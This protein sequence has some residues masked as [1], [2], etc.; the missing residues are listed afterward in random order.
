[1][2]IRIG[3]RGK[4]Q[5]AQITGVQTLKGY[6]LSVGVNATVPSGALPDV[7]MGFAS[8]D[9]NTAILARKLVEALESAGIDWRDD[10]THRCACGASLENEQVLDECDACFAKRCIPCDRC[11]GPNE[12]AN[13]SNYCASCAAEFQAQTRRNP[14]CSPVG[15][16]S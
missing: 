13:E 10:G 2:R 7:W 9:P 4:E 5:P 15:G 16:Q 11:E 1:M 12:R 6:G 8:D 3:K 14:E